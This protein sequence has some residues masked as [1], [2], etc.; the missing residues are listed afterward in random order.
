M[1]APLPI[2]PITL[3]EAKQ[4]IAVR[5]LEQLANLSLTREPSTAEP[6]P[7]SEIPHGL[8]G[9]SSPYD[10]LV[11]W[12]KENAPQ[13]KEAVKNRAFGGP[14][15]SPI[16]WTNAFL[17]FMESASVY[18]RDSAK[19]VEAT[20][21]YKREDFETAF[22]LL[23][24]STKQI[25]EIAALWGMKFQL[26]CDLTESSST[27]GSGPYCGAFYSDDPAAPFIGVGFK[28]TNIWNWKDLIT[29]INTTVVQ[30]AEGN[31]Y[32][33]QVSDGVYSGLFGQHDPG[34]AIDLIR[35]GINDLIPNIPN[36]H[37]KE[38][39]THVT[40]HS[41]GGSYSNLCYTQFTI[42]G[43]LPP[44][45]VLGDLYTFGCPRIGYKDFAEAMRDH[46][47]PHTGSA[48]RIGNKGD[49]V[50]QVPPVTPWTHDSPFNH[51]N[52]GYRLYESD[53]PE[54]LPS[55]IG[56]LTSGP[57]IWPPSKMT[58]TPHYATTYYANLRKATS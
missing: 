27:W 23:D 37:G 14:D 56:T 58:F 30:A 57:D 4:N 24:E 40:G 7:E 25:Q 51:V 20:E 36:E 31:L 9:S 22:K 38:V 52:A 54:L 42:P 39:V 26:L 49:L 2:P 35:Q 10:D 53:K 12:S 47:G 19:V 11:E 34:R 16:N 43:V 29:D 28:G 44:M 46:L 6:G 50:T 5:H 13:I 33:T 8:F 45:G 32:N 3:H 15:G 41:L 55:E 1:Q 21:A 48:W 17:P 18:L